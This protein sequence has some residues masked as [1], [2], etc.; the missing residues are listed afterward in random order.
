MSLVASALAT[1]WGFAAD[2]AHAQSAKKVI[3]VTTITNYPQFEFKDASGKLVGLDIDIFNAMAAKM[4]AEVN[5][6]ESSFDQ[7]ISF[8]PIK[9]K[10]ADVIIAAMTDTPERRAN[11]SFL[12][13]VYVNQV[14]FTLRTNI[15]RFPNMEAVCG[16][17]VA[18]SR[19]SVVEMGAVEKWSEENCTKASKPAINLVPGEGTPQNR[20]MVKQGRVEAALTSDATIA[21][22]NML[23]GNQYVT[24]G[25]PL[26]K[27]MYGIGFLKDDPQFGDALKKALAAIIADGTY[28]QLLRKW[29]LTDASSIQ[30]PML[31]GEP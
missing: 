29:N 9:T 1:A 8:A 6:I 10:R 15:D 14:L 13:Y 22:Q 25:K 17:S 12:D 24:F 31:N 7:L 30:Q 28:G 3:N 27:T 2:C 16:K 11:A 5:W 21:Y 4:G 23:E 18:A 19:T 20:L 26:V